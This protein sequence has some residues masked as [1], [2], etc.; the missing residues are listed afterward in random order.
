[1]DTLP[2]IIKQTLLELHIS[3]HLHGYG[4]LAYNIEQVVIDPLR[5]H[6]VTKDLYQ[7]TARQ[8][9]TTWQAGH[10]LVERLWATEFIA[11]VAGYIREVCGQ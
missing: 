9:G 10:H 3:P 2:E 4:Y 7:E 11:I 6:G 1:M 5:I 8:H